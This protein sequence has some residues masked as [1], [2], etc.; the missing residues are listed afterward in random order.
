MATMA[1]K[2]TTVYLEEDLLR[3][4]KVMAART[5]KKDYEVFEAALKEFLGL[6]ILERTQGRSDLSEEEAMAL[7]N[8]EVHAVRRERARRARQAGR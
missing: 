3:A 1:R 5:G 7:A 2:K 6:G 8:E 4:A